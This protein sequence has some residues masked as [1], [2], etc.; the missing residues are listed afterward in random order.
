MLFR[1]VILAGILGTAANAL[2]VSLLFGAPLMPLILSPGRNA[3]AILVAILLIPIF[4]RMRG[5][6]AWIT[7]LIL[8]TVIPSILAKTVFAAQ[9]PWGTVLGLN[10]VYALVATIIFVAIRKG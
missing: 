2:A 1:S 10:S 8:L 7:A 9:A 4:A 3:V 6:G 5:A